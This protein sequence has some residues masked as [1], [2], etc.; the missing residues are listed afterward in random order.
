MK[1]FLYALST[2]FHCQRTKKWLTENNVD[3]DY[4][5]VDLAEGDERTKLVN[6]V[7][8]MTGASQFPVVKLGDK[9]VVGFNEEK[10]KELL[11]V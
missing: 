8:E 9:H 10:L 5:D 11:G 2:C 1:P 7:Q 4:V 3:Y 6:E